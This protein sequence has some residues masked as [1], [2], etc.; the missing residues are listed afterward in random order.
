VL[1]AREESETGA[2]ARAFPDTRAP[3]KGGRISRPPEGCNCA[4]S[5]GP[6]PFADGFTEL[7]A[8]GDIK[9]ENP[10]GLRR[11]SHLRS[12]RQPSNEHGVT[13]PCLCG[14]CLQK[15]SNSP[16]RTPPRNAC[17]SSGV[18]RRTGPAE[19]LLLRTPISPWGRLATSTQLPFE[20]LRE[21]FTQQ[22][23]D[24]GLPGGFPNTGLPTVITSLIGV[25]YPEGPTTRCSNT[26]TNC[27]YRTVRPT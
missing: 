4:T 5:S 21:L 20:K 3:L 6:G 14:H 9:A 18:N 1:L 13:T 10:S 15:R 16:F 27:S 7:V 24:S 11:D 19:S 17:H 26:A 12:G 25:H 2:R 8:D 23:P 22:G